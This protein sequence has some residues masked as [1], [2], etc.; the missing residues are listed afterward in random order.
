MDR[1]GLLRSRAPPRTIMSHAALD[2]PHR[3]P[4]RVLGRC[5]IEVSALGIGCWAIGGEDFNLGLP[6]GWTGADEAA[7]IAGLEKA[8]ELGATLFDTADIYGHGRSERLLGRLVAQVPRSSIVVTSKV[9]YF[10]G[11][12]PH[13]YHPPHMRHQLEQSLDNL[14]TDYLD[15]YFLH[16]ADFGPDDVQLEG[17]VQAM[18]AFQ[19]EGLIRAVGMRGPHRYALERLGATTV[20]EGKVARFERL[21]E[22]V[23][24]DVL[25]VR[26]N[27]LTPQV[28]SAGI[29]SFATAH[30]CGVLINKPLA[31]GLLTGS[32]DPDRQRSFGP[33]DHRTRKRW[34][35]PPAVR[36]IENGLSQL[37]M[38]FGSEPGDLIRIALWSCLD[39][40]PD[41]AVLVGFTR[42]E[43]VETNLTC[44]GPPPAA[45]VLHFAREVMAGVQQQ[46]DAT[47]EV[48][49]D[50]V[51]S[52]SGA[53]S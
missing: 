4:P 43:Q 16:H 10:S 51:S 53:Q 34:F 12:A 39:R 28:R 15:I 48:F 26:D 50:E 14:G 1:K 6:M 3:L 2:P 40:S 20:R 17:A 38:R 18:H 25:A 47:G 13:G 5:G 8:Y 31:Q 32:Y 30:Q 23:R 7:S 37:R 9:G 22:R 46:L 42:P 36:I 49:L 52:R 41:T 44:L 21:F 35:T 45:E 27:L 11:T 33:G 29:F 24:P 19:A